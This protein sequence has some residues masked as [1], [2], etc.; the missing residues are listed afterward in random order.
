M[1]LKP[2]TH[3]AHRRA[4]LKSTLDQGIASASRAALGSMMRGYKLQG[5]KPSTGTRR[6]P[7]AHLVRVRSGSS[8]INSLDSSID[9][10]IATALVKGPATSG[11]LS[12]MFGL[13]PNLTGR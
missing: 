10:M 8:L 4:V 12:S 1:K 6:A 5:A 2:P 3:A 9:H 11:V 13:S 7:R